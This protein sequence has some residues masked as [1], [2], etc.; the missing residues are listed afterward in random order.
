MERYFITCGRVETDR[1]HLKDGELPVIDGTGI[2]G[3]DG[4]GAET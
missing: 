4:G 3:G 1:E 2:D